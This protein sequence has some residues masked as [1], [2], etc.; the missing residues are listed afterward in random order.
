MN[1]NNLKL[2]ILQNYYIYYH[3]D[4]IEELPNFIKV[5]IID[6]LEKNNSTIDVCLRFSYC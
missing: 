4:S 5:A 1:L 3:K 6:S 2:H